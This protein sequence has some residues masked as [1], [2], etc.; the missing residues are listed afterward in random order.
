M[1]N[2]LRGKRPQG[3]CGDVATS[4][5]GSLNISPYDRDHVHTAIVRLAGTTVDNS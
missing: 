2:Q 5:P 4:R 1:H 3:V